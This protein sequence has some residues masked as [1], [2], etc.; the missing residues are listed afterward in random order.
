MLDNR[1]YNNKPKNEIEKITANE[2]KGIN[3]SKKKEYEEDKKGIQN[4]SLKN[5][6]KKENNI[7]SNNKKK[8]RN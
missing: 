7:I 1:L 5:K 8:K 2:E 4:I 3:T 6:T